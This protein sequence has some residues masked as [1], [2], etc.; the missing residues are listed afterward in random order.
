MSSQRNEFGRD[1]R[2]RNSDEIEQRLDVIHRDVH[3]VIEMLE[4]MEKRNMSRYTDLRTKV[5][6]IR[7]QGDALREILK[8]LDGGSET[9]Y[10]ELLAE[11]Q[12]NADEI[13]ADIVANTPA[14]G[15]STGNVP[16]NG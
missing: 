1:N 4:K 9:E 10:Q 15:G 11:L 3:R 8:T 14:S 5:Q 2:E 16:P 13:A 6:G 7:R 12:A